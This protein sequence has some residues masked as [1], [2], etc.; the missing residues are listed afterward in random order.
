MKKLI[1]LLLFA[2][3]LLSFETSFAQYSSIPITRTILHNANPRTIQSKTYF[4]TISRSPY[5][6]NDRYWHSYKLRLEAGE[7]LY[8]RY[9]SPAY[10][11]ALIVCDSAGHG[12]FLKKDTVP[13]SMGNNSSTEFMTPVNISG[14]YYLAVSTNDANAIGNYGLQISDLFCWG[15]FQKYEKQNLDWFNVYK[16][17]IRFD[18]QFL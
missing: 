14:D 5:Y 16:D 12:L 6:F 3:P 13:R 15:I 10:S 18:E 17:K 2:L 1:P 4:D 8:V 9:E 11:V 7:Q